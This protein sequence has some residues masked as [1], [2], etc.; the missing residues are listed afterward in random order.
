MT[1]AF[2][3]DTSLAVIAYTEGQTREITRVTLEQHV[4]AMIRWLE[5]LGIQPGDRVLLFAPN[6]IEWVV[7]ALATLRSNAIIVPVDTQMS[8][9]DLTHV[10]K[11]SAPT[12]ICVSEETL[13]EL[14]FQPDCQWLKI[15]TIETKLSDYVDTNHTRASHAPADEQLAALFYT[16]GTTGAP[17]GVPLTHGNLRSNVNALLEENIAKASDRVLLPLPLHHVYP[18]SIGLLT[19]LAAGATMVLPRSLVG[20][21][22]AEALRDSNASILLGVPRLYEV[23]WARLE[24]RITKQRPWAAKIFHGLLNTCIQ[25]NARFGWH[26]GRWLFRPIMKRLAPGLRL[27]VS[28]GA[29]LA[30]E[31]GARLNA[32]GWTIATGYGLTETSPILT[33]NAPGEGKLN[34]AGRPLS[35]VE[36]R[37]VDGEV[38]ARGPNVFNG[39]WNDPVPRESIIDDKGWFKTGDAGEIGEDGYL[40]LGGRLSA[41]IVLPG[42]ENIDPE[43]IE[44]ALSAH[45]MI[46]EAGVLDNNGQLVAILVPE[47]DT[48]D[49][50]DPLDAAADTI[51]QTL[52]SHHQVRQFARSPDPLPRTRLGKLRRHKLTALYQTLSHQNNNTLNQAPIQPEEMAPEDRALLADPAANATWTL[53][54]ERFHDHRL[55][56]DSR[57]S[58]DLGLDSL[59]W[60]DLGISIS[61]RAGVELADDAIARVETV[62]DLLSECINAEQA[63]EQ[64]PAD[65][66]RSALSAALAN[67]ERLLEPRDLRALAPRGPLRHAGAGA[68]LLG[69]QLINFLFARIEVEGALPKGG[70][71]LIAPR[72]VS[73]YDPIALTAALSRQELEPVFW[74]GLSGL[75]FKGPVQR[76]FSYVARV[77]PIDPGAAPRRSLALA[78]ACLQR[79]HSLIWFPEGQRGQEDGVLQPLRPG[80][81]RLLAAHPV[82]VVP[83]WIEGAQNVLPIGSVIPRRGHIRIII[84]AP[85]TAD[86]YGNDERGIVSA[87]ANAITAIKTP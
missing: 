62:R 41:T 8:R 10:L 73:A 17:K 4:C 72:H 54:T 36:L 2:Q 53:L 44:R 61:E 68:A 67:P 63:S 85:I 77:L 9:D 37:I 69:C 74:A 45:P 40:R 47:P 60:V 32:L 87:V 70:P 24:A 76:T 43:R 27:A 51:I 12:I 25:T 38:Q 48:T 81:G 30:P 55:T 52:P 13:G 64:A 20:P 15:E 22:I 19:V 82:P 7:V 11:D 28:G 57:L 18:F 79:G 31:L 5:S 66:K 50:P 16:S 26:P 65:G 58:R 56:P 46:R 84:G 14:P 23:I 35:N 59:S 34:T 83:V 39:Y 75:L 3:A 86:D 6:S 1:I 42:G 29:A 80:I 49:G 71:F 33:L 78:A 21:R